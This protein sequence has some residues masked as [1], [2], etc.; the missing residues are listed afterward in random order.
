MAYAFKNYTVRKS[1]I[2]KSYY[3]GFILKENGRLLTTSDGQRHILFLQ[4]IDSGEPDLEWGRLKV[5][6]T[7]EREMVLSIQAFAVNCLDYRKGN[8]VIDLETRRIRK[9]IFPKRISQAQKSLLAVKMF[10]YME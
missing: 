2:E 9:F 5:D 6:V 3:R 7:M 8:H 10:C 1:R 4:Y